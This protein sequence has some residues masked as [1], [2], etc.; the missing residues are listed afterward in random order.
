MDA[1]IVVT[2]NA[3]PALA[4]ANETNSAR[5]IASS[6]QPELVQ[7]RFAAEREA[8][9]LR[10]RVR[11]LA[12]ELN[13]AQE[14]ARVYLAQEL[15][16][17]VGAELTAA[18]FALASAKHHLPASAPQFVAAITVAQQA[19]DAA[20]E[21]SRHLVEHLG[22]RRLDAGIVSVL[23]QWTESFA[24]RTR[25]TSSFVCPDDIR[26]AQL[27]HGAA[28]A[29]FRVAQEALSN[30]AK[31]AGASHVDVR[32]D[33]HHEYVTLIVE[34]NGRG[35]GRCARNETR[36]FG[37]AG[38]RARCEAYGGKLRVSSRR[39]GRGPLPV[40][41]TGGTTVWARFS[42]ESMMAGDMSSRSVSRP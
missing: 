14:S 6:I 1:S 38:M 26:L 13:A 9:A 40:R 29:L 34:D 7:A 2:L 17:S 31:H 21:A 37:L 27:P 11:E 22:A 10:K 5:G 12:A 8:N 23:A 18:R 19:L 20:S 16:D 3:I 32:I 24:A 35:M 15:H 25:L 30:A 42:W 28:L 36:G 4:P 41:E 39:P 33:T